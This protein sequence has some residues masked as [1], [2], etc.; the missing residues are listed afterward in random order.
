MDSCIPVCNCN[1]SLGNTG[2]DCLTLM[3]VAQ[4]LIFMQTYDSTGNQ[5]YMDLTVTLDQA[6]FSA[7]INQTDKSKRWYVTPDLNNVN[8]KRADAV[9]EKMS[10]DT[11]EHIR[12]GVGT[13]EGVFLKSKG[14]PKMKK[15]IDTLRCNEVSALVIDKVGNIYGHRSTDDTKLYPIRL[16]AGSVNAI[17]MKPTDST[18]PKLSIKFNW[19]TSENDACLGLVSANDLASDA[20]PLAWKGLLDVKVKFSAISTAGVT[21]TLYTDFGTVLAPTT[22]KGAV[23]AEFISYYTSATSKARNITSGAEVSL[24]SVTETPANSGIYVIVFAAAQTVGHKIAFKLLKTGYD[25]DN[26]VPLPVTIA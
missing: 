6:Y 18:V 11:E 9:T 8:D 5:N 21:A 23:I 2:Y 17:L 16:D 10:D 19:H 15:S 13:F 1:A 12:D 7:K 3:D 4:K 25:G 24:T 26:M 22:V 14:S 20:T